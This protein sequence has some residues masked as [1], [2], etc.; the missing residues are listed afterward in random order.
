MVNLC[1]APTLHSTHTLSTKLKQSSKFSSSR[2][3]RRQEDSSSRQTAWSLTRNGAKTCKTITRGILRISQQPGPYLK[4]VTSTCSKLSQRKME[5]AQTLA[6]A[7]CK[8]IRRSICLQRNLKSARSRRRPTESCPT[9]WSTTRMFSVWEVAVIKSLRSIKHF[10]WSQIW[11][12]STPLQLSLKDL[13]NEEVSITTPSIKLTTPTLIA[14]PPGPLLRK[15]S[16]DL[17]QI[18]QTPRILVEGKR[19]MARKVFS[20]RWC[21]YIIVWSQAP[22]KMDRLANHSH[23]ALKASRKV[24]TC[25]W[26]IILSLTQQSQPTPVLRL[27]QPSPNNSIRSHRVVEIA[28]TRFKTTIHC[29]IWAVQRLWIGE[30][31]VSR[32]SE[33]ESSRE[34]GA[35]AVGVNLWAKGEMILSSM[36][37]M[38][39]QAHSKCPPSRKRL[40]VRMKMAM[41]SSKQGIDLGPREINQMRIIGSQAS[42]LRSSSSTSTL[43]LTIDYPWLNKNNKDRLRTW[44]RKSR[45]V[46]KTNSS[47]KP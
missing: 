38:I 19:A 11:R 15:S 29:I 27:R 9:P 12:T 16:V 10:S 45:T 47:S 35:W 34:M 36:E 4:V 43:S 1:P 41:L 20:P 5:V 21:S 33:S 22:D 44:L 7:W 30:L 26:R 46:I 3:Y 40:T 6:V 32:A 14:S 18:L 8:T 2:T 42:R 31:V 25:R 39:W 13:T 37:A 24:S 23:P 17:V 28:T